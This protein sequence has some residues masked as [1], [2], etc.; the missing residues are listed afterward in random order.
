[1]TD[2]ISDLRS[3]ILSY[4]GCFEKGADGKGDVSMAVG[5]TLNWH[6]VAVCVECSPVGV[7]GCLRDADR[8]LRDLSPTVC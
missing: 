1:M 8:S 5:E 3:A 4:V 7:V 6:P 2:G